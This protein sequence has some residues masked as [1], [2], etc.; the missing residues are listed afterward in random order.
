MYSCVFVVIE[1]E[2][3]AK[4][5]SKGLEDDPSTS[6]D[7]DSTWDDSNRS[8]ENDSNNISSRY[9]PANCKLSEN[10]ILCYMFH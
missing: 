1:P 6:Y 7:D 4:N 8:V 3:A 9:S 10:V 5:D 2:T